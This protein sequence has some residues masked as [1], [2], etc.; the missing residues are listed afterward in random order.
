MSD[1][2]AGVKQKMR[3]IQK[4]QSDQAEKKGSKIQLLKQL[5]EEH[6]VDTLKEAELILAAYKAEKSKNEQLLKEVD[7]ELA[8]IISSAN[9]D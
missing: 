3:T 9:S 5:K 8:G 4:L 2:I 1:L 6:D 7:E